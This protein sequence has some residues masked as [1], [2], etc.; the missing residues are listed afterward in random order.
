MADAAPAPTSAPLDRPETPRGLGDVLTIGF[1]TVVVMWTA[2]YVSRMLPAGTVPPWLLLVLL[3]VIQ[4]GGGWFLGKKTARTIASALG[5]GL[6]ISLLNMLVLGA[7][8]AEGHDAAEIA[9]GVA[10]F[11]ATTIV[12]TV[13]GFVLGRMGRPAS[14]PAANWT[15]WFAKVAVLATFILVIAGGLVTGHEAG[16]AVPDWPNTEGALMF[17]YPLS[18]MTGGVYYEHAHRLYGALV[19]V[20]TIAFAAHI[21]VADRV[22]G[23]P[24]WWLRQVAIV[25][26]V[27]VCIQGVLGGLRVTGRLTL[28]QDAA[29]LEPNL[30]LAIVHGVSGQL[31]LALMVSI[32]AFTSTTWRRR[33]NVLTHPAAGTDRTLSVVLVALLIL[34]LTLGAS[35]R[36]LS[37]DPELNQGM[38]MGI[39]HTHIVVAVLVLGAIL[40][41]GIRAAGMYAEQPRVKKT[42]TGLMHIVGLQILLGIV[43][44]VAVL[45]REPADPI[46]TWEVI[47][48]TL[49][50]ATGAALLA[51]ATLHAIWVRRLLSAAYK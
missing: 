33:D 32:A 26:V 37:T 49:H 24:R 2:G 47:V 15:G 48:T 27:F 7:V 43:A 17:L 14:R 42:G 21:W 5:T 39:L 18:K 16:L 1:G 12:L 40:F 38:V 20:T 8:L 25:A 45:R 41:N 28:S 3:V 10:G 44:M 46:P 22:E 6:L 30:T 4:L 23:R 13:I 50:Q 31:F 19:G 11:I 36:H 51:L 29:Q 9:I 35:F 34:Q